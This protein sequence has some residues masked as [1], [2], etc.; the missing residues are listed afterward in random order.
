MSHNCEQ[1][2]SVTR[3]WRTR[4]S[5]GFINKENFFAS[6]GNSIKYKLLPVSGQATHNY[7]AP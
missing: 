4:C 6:Q 7:T 3:V 5:E 2:E 1:I